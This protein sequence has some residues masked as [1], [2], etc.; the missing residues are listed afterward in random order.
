MCTL[1]I[2]ALAE[3]RHSGEGLGICLNTRNLLLSY[4]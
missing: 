4:Y 2:R 3:Y 1:A